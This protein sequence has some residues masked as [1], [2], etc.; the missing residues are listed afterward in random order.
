MST[1]T[2]VLRDSIHLTGNNG[3]DQMMYQ[4]N[5]AATWWRGT[6]GRSV[7]PGFHLTPHEE[8][9]PT[10]RHAT[11]LWNPGLHPK[12]RTHTMAQ[13]RCYRRCYDGVFPSTK[14][15]KQHT[16]RR[17]LNELMEGHNCCDLWSSTWVVCVCCSHQIIQRKHPGCDPKTLV[18]PLSR[19]SSTV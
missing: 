2:D 14:K 10:A 17:L 5:V 13:D 7:G 15:A 11:V 3:N 6:S 16:T 1:D 19:V 12:A 8:L 4:V 9:P 18:I